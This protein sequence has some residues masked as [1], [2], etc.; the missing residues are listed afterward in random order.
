MRNYAGHRLAPWLAHVMVSRQE[1]SRPLLTAG[2]VMQLP[3]GDELVMVSGLAPVRAR[4]IRYFSDRNFQSRVRSAPR[5]S[6]RRYPD[7]PAA[8]AHDWAETRGRVAAPAWAGEPD[9]LLA[10]EGGLQKIRKPLATRRRRPGP[11]PEQLDLLGLGDDEAMPTPPLPLAAAHAT[12]QGSG[13]GDELLP[14]F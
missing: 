10:D 5:L 2:E 8:R 13:R 14:G 6:G 4:K 3:P 12:N 1:T 9:G 7:A 11:A